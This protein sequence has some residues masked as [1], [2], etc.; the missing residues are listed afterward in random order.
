M[1]G[2]RPVW[3]E[4]NLDNLAHNF[5]EVK[6]VVKDEVLITAVIKADGYGHGAVE[7]AK[8]LLENGANRFA[9]ATFSEA[10]QLRKKYNDIPIMVLGY[11]PNDSASSVVEH[12]IIQTIYSYDQAAVYS[13]EARKINS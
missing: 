10:I 1:K 9:V 6:R 7:I 13:D 2:L 8:T 12:N 4:I 3:A 5:Q 11:T